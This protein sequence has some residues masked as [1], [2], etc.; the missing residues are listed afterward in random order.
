[1]LTTTRQVS[2]TEEKVLCYFGSLLVVQFTHTKTGNMHT[3]TRDCHQL[4]YVYPLHLSDHNA[5]VSATFANAYHGASEELVYKAIAN[6]YKRLITEVY[7][8]I[9]MGRF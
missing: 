8:A 4:M 3:F 6:D 9:D 7:K 5:M 2:P 1:M